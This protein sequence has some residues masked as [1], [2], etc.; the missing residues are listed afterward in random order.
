[1]ALELTG[2]PA[3]LA[4]GLDPAAYLRAVNRA[5]GQ[6]V[7]AAGG[8]IERHYRIGGH[9]IRLRFAGPALVPRL[10]PAFAHLAAP[11]PGIPELTVSLWDSASTRTP[12]PPPRWGVDDL[13]PRGEVRGYTTD[14]VRTAYDPTSMTVSMLDL[15]SG[16]AVFWARSASEMAYYESGAPLRALLHWWMTA[17]RLHC[18]HAAAVGTNEEGVLLVGKGGSGKSTTA[19]TCV[20]A[21]MAYV[22][23]DYCLLQTAGV[24]YVHSLYSSA[25]LDP[26]DLDRFPGLAPAVSNAD[27]LP[28]EKALLFLHQHRPTQTVPGLTV[29]AVLL[30]RIMRTPKTRLV[31]TSAAAALLA[32]APSTLFQLQPARPDALPDISRLLRQV[33]CYHLE[34]GSDSPQTIPGSVLRALRGN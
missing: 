24:P 29:K 21:G 9:T 2:G 17:R 5:F 1:V 10:T 16:L 23:D 33:P 7:R 13:R 6:A 30:P 34:L 15:E 11:A 12:M 8:A 3:G 27:R 32:L 18:A 19:L 31:R 25:K 4:E 20:A 22:G 28:T 14:R 26:Q